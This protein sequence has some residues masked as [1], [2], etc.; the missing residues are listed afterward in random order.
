V[1]E[2]AP[3]AGEPDDTEPGGEAGSE[4]VEDDAEAE[5]EEA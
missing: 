3:E 1:E 5:N 4:S 2:A